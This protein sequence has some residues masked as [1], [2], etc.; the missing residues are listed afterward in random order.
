MIA[1]RTPRRQGND[2]IPARTEARP[3]GAYGK[4]T[5]VWIVPVSR[6]VRALLE[7]LFALERAFR[8]KNRWAPNLVKEVVNRFLGPR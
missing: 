5:K 6:W 3:P 4:A 2:V 7:H 8:V 1:A